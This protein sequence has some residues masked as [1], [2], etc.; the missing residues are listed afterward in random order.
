MLG[1]GREF[2]EMT[3]GHESITPESMRRGGVQSRDASEPINQVEL[4]HPGGRTSQSPPKRMSQVS[5]SIRSPQ[6]PK[7]S[8][9]N[10]PHRRQRARPEGSI[11][12]LRRPGSPGAEDENLSALIEKA[13]GGITPQIRLCA[14]SIPHH[15]LRFR[16]SVERVRP[17]VASDATLLESPERCLRVL[18]GAV[19]RDVT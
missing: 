17:A 13:N 10:W 12:A 5:R 7:L 16:I 3:T 9:P 14:S 6:S 15:T 18:M 11:A 1:P 8:T 2:T 4:T 19:D